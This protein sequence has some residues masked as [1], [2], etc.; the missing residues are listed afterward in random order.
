[1]SR[2]RF[3]P[4]GVSSKTHEN[5]S[6]NGKPITPI[7]TTTGTIQSGRCSAGATVDV[8]WV[9]TQPSARYAALALNTFRRLSSANRF[10]RTSLPYSIGVP[11]QHLTRVSFLGQFELLQ[12]GGI[13]RIVA[14]A[15][16]Q[17]V[18][19]DC[20]QLGIMLC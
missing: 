17:R 10:M 15:T 5:T 14:Q 12:Q 3:S 8:T 2:S 6:T 13:T 4:S 11:Q 20:D 1:M 18:V 7:H 19:F 9:T 16:Q